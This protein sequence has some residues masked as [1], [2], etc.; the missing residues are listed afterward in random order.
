M[1]L[2]VRFYYPHKSAVWFLTSS[3]TEDRLSP[4][5]LS[6]QNQQQY[7]PRPGSSL[8]LNS[9]RVRRVTS[10]QDGAPVSPCLA[11]SPY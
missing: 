9:A 3:A 5:L 6:S 4:R 1:P 11:V 7:A 10:E 8:G 2:E